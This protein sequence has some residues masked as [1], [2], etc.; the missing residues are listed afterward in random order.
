MCLWGPCT[1]TTITVRSSKGV[2]GFFANLSASL[3]PLSYV[4]SSK[5]WEDAADDLSSR[6]VEMM[7]SK[8]CALTL[9]QV[10]GGAPKV[11]SSAV[12]TVDIPLTLRDA[13][14]FQGMSV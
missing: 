9:Y 14:V 2:V 11:S 12:G 6:L 8:V 13:P 1:H 3:A 4:S 5:T 10:G 7:D